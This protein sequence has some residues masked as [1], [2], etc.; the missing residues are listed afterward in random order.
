M[1]N[2]PLYLMAM[3]LVMACADKPVKLVI[4]PP[5]GSE[6]KSAQSHVLYQ[7]Q[8]AAT[9]K[10]E[11]VTIPVGQLPQRLLIEE[12]SQKSDAAIPSATLADQRF[13]G[14]SGKTLSVSY[15]KGIEKVEK[16]YQNQKYQDALISLAPL[17]EEYPNQAKLHVMQGTIYRRLGEK[18]HAYTAYKKALALDTNNLRVQQAVDKLEAEIGVVGE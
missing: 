4:D 7:T 8:D 16:L 5:A 18:R 15:L 1:K 13:A 11:T 3:C 17:V 6:S 9:G 10:T 12:K 2:S 14:E